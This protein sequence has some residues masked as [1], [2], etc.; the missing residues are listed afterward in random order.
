MKL[1]LRLSALSVTMFALLAGSLPGAP[2]PTIREA[3]T[4]PVPAEPGVQRQDEPPDAGGRAVFE[5]ECASCHGADGKGLQTAGTPDLTDFRSRAGISTE[6]IVDI[7]SEGESG[8]ASG[9]AMPAFGGRLSETE[10]LEVASF[11]Q[12]LAAANRPGVYLPADDFVYT[13]P[14]GRQ[15]QRGT[16]VVNFTHRWAFNPAFS[17]SG[18]GNI[19]FGLD[20]FSISS[21]GLRYGVTGKLSVSAFRSPSIINRPIEF[22]AAYGLFDEYAGQPLNATVRVSIDG[23][24]NFRRNFT[25]NIEGILSRSITG[26]AQVYMVPTYSFGNRVLVSK[27]GPLADRPAPLPGI[28]SFSLGVGLAVNIRPSVALVAEVIPT[29]Y[30][31]PELEIHRPSY[32]IG[33]QK[34]IAG[35]AFTLGVSNGPGTTV[36]QRAGTRASFLGD[37]SADLPGDL[38]IGFNLMRRLR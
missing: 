21:F 33:I 6:R 29:L 9:T 7:V 37:P 30:H 12:S 14:T 26:R 2:S 17:G 31:G 3:G 22:M 36:A 13:L 25:T 28:D 11:V 24:D 38:F 10:I 20:G 23:Q 19:L 16:L 18:L 5:R 32:A 4:L 35:H 34:Q 8:T 27:P 15:T 1:R